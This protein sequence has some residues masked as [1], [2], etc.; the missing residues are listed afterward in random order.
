[1]RKQTCLYSQ[2]GL[3]SHNWHPHEQRL[4]D[5][6][7]LFILIQCHGVAPFSLQPYNAFGKCFLETM[8]TKK[9]SFLIF[10]RGRNKDNVVQISSLSNI[11]PS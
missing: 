2:I 4:T 1:M 9:K 11:A 10:P 8:K 3:L 5:R 7:P 6:S